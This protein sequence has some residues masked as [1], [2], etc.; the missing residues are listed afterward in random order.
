MIAAESERSTTDS[1]TLLLR[2][3]DFA[4]HTSFKPATSTSILMARDE[5]AIL[6]HFSDHTF[7]MI[8]ASLRFRWFLSSEI[9]PKLIVTIWDARSLLS[10]AIP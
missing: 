3:A 4:D 8:C 1:V 7:T 2:V 9:G 10:G 6:E 5:L